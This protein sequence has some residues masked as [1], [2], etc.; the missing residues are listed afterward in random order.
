ML[1]SDDARTLVEDRLRMA[2]EQTT[3]LSEHEQAVIAEV[4]E[5]FAAARVSK[6]RPNKPRGPAPKRRRGED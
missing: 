6:E 4:I 3:Y 5:A 2:I 1:F